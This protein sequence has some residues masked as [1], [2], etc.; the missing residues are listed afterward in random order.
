MLDF[1][2]LTEVRYFIFGDRSIS[3]DMLESFN[4]ILQD[5]NMLKTS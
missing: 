1:D 4:A 2:G 3:G 5:Y